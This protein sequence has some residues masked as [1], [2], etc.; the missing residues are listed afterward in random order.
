MGFEQLRVWQESM[1][2]VDEI[3]T[4]IRA[5][6]LAKDFDLRSQMRRAAVSIPSNIAEGDEL[7]TNK[8]ANR[9]FY[10]ARGSAA[11]L[12]TQITIARR[13]GYIN[14]DTEIALNERLKMI[15]RMLYKLIKAREK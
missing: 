4:L 12:R 14:K 8:Q 6:E 1:D 10:I 2:V 5:G 9:H 15:S 11:E 13:Q 3:Y 7:D